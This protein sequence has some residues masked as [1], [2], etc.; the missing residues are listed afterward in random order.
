MAY[1]LSTSLRAAIDQE[2]TKFPKEQRRSALIKS[3]FCAQKENNGFLTEEIMAAL[4][5]YLQIAK[6]AVYEVAS[7]YS[8]FD[9]KAT[10]PNK[11]YVCT[12]LSC[13][14]RGS[15]EIVCYLKDKLGIEVNEITACGKITLKEAECLAACG[16]AP[17]MQV[18]NKYELDLTPE[19]IDK[20]IREFSDEY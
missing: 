2:L 15:D 5:E 18:N 14:L 13:M 6:V 9:T 7:F 19:K 16:N 4:A 8:M 11:F 20:I 12:S 10:A 3:L 1:E 17:M